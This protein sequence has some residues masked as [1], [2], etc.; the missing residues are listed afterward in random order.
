IKSIIVNARYMIYVYIAS[1]SCIHTYVIYIKAI[2]IP[3][4]SKDF[5]ICV[6]SLSIPAIINSD[7]IYNI[8]SKKYIIKLVS[9]LYTS[10]LS[11]S[12]NNKNTIPDNISNNKYL[13]L[14]FC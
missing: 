14:I 2:T 4:I 8:K 1:K 12:A 11:E 9:K 3:N 10:A 6:L 7:A 5:C 13:I